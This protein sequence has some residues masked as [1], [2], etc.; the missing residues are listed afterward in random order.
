M[1]TPTG[2]KFLHHAAER[3]DVGIYF[4]ANGHGTVLF[5]PSLVERLQ[6]LAESGAAAAGLLAL[7]QL[8]NQVQK[9]YY[10]P[11]TTFKL[12][13]C[14]NLRKRRGHGAAFGGA[15]AAAGEVRCGRGGPSGSLAADIQIQLIGLFR[16]S[17]ESNRPSLEAAGAASDRAAAFLKVVLWRC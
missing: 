5:A 10:A 1:V 17:S 14:E 12:T 16:S 8:N 6:P 11:N 2:V 3:F 7:E 9:C 4:E 15:A 13:F